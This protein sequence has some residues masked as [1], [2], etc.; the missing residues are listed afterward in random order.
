M[1]LRVYYSPLLCVINVYLLTIPR[2]IM[3]VC[4]PYIRIRIYLLS[5]RNLLWD[6]LRLPSSHRAVLGLC[7]IL[8]LWRARGA[9]QPP[10]ALLHVGARRAMHCATGDD[11][12]SHKPTWKIKWHLP[13]PG[14]QLTLGMA[15]CLFWWF[16]SW[17]GVWC[18]ICRG[19]SLFRDQ[20]SSLNIKLKLYLLTH[21]L[22]HC[23]LYLWVLC[24]SVSAWYFSAVDTT[25]TKFSSLCIC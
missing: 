25:K 11:T 10:Y 14:W 6:I 17:K 18:S 8:I 19:M 3:L 24:L 15:W 22:R 16:M 12:F 23:T 4:W 5:R 13:F 20:S 21:P 7:V 2:V 9:N 1:F